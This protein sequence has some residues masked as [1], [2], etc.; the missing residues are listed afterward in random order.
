LSPYVSRPPRALAAG[1][2]LVAVGTIFALLLLSL[3]I[4]R[5]IEQAS[6]LVSLDLD[7]PPPPPPAER[8]ARQ[9]H[10]RKP[11]PK[12]AASPENTRNKATAV[13]VPPVAR[14]VPPP[15]VVS[16]PKAGPGAAADNGA[17]N[18]PGPG[19][20]AGGIGN[21]TGGGGHGGDG[22]GDGDGDSVEGPRRIAG[23]LH[24]SDLP[25][26]VLAPGQEA[27][28]SVIDTVEA[29]G[30]VSHCKVE[31]SSGYPGLDRL[32]CQLNVERYRYR[33]ARDENGRPVWSREE[34]SETW[35]ARE[36]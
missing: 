34:H 28:V 3:N 21:G 6:R 23:S 26:G 9:R 27:T 36:R 10:A 16:A 4:P 2:S 14:I 33:P 35:T 22:H 29:D 30:H 1:T 20:G 11:A 31:H 17:A 7:E 13:V 8:P 24:Y 15:P 18:R 12:H 19:Q 32:A 5:A 25:E